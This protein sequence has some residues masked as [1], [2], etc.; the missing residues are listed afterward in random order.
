MYPIAT[1]IEIHTWTKIHFN[2]I[3]III[4]V[5]QLDPSHYHPFTFLAHENNMVHPPPPP[6]FFWVNVSSGVVQIILRLE[7]KENVCSNK[8][9][10]HLQ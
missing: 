3:H 7:T 10:S 8:T 4:I 6:Q 9:Q 5:D 1:V 2:S